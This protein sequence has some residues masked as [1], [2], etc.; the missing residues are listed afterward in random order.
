[1]LEKEMIIFMRNRVRKALKKASKKG[2]NVTRNKALSI[3]L[4]V[5]MFVSQVQLL[6]IFMPI[7]AAAEEI[8]GGQASNEDYYDKLKRDNLSDGYHSIHNFADKF[9]VRPGNYFNSA[10]GCIGNCITSNSRYAKNIEFYAQY[11]FDEAGLIALNAKKGNMEVG[12]VLYSKNTKVSRGI[13]D[14]FI[15]PDYFESHAYLYGYKSNGQS[16]LIKE[17][18]WGKTEASTKGV[19]DSNEIAWMSMH[20]HPFCVIKCSKDPYNL[21]FCK[22]TPSD[23]PRCRIFFFITGLKH[24][25][26]F[27]ALL[28]ALIISCY[29]NC[30]GI[31]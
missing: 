14:I 5:L 15:E 30:A 24:F 16:Y 9:I 22:Y 18:F 20:D 31:L 27:K 25:K 17:Y 19:G 1:L 23:V 2:L 4:I 26:D 7:T 29:N 12:L 11:D 10:G 3:I 21:D 8:P 28:L 13:L 6:F